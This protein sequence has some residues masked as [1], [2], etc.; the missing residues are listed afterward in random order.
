MGEKSV[1][2]QTAQLE[3]LKQ[4]NEKAHHQQVRRTT[5]QSLTLLS[6]DKKIQ[7]QEKQLSELSQKIEDT[8]NLLDEISAVAYDKAVAIVSENAVSDALKASTE[9]VDIYLDW[10]KEPGRTA[11]KETLDYTTYQITTLR[12]NIIAA[13]NRITARLTTVLIKPEIKKPAIEQ[14]KEN[15]RPSVLQNPVWLSFSASKLTHGLCTQKSRSI[16]ASLFCSKSTLCR[17]C[18]I[19]AG[20]SFAGKSK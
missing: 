4:E 2:E 8:E 11:S 20:Y 18:A 6:N 12:K 16:P 5:Y 13:V 15:T 1:Q 14:I 7:K 9:Q 10:L 17:P 3:N 19:S